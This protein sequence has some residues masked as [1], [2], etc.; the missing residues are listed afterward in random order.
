MKKKI[1]KAYYGKR[2]VAFR[3]HVIQTKNGP[4]KNRIARVLCEKIKLKTNT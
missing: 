1:P 4:T 3:T 2:R